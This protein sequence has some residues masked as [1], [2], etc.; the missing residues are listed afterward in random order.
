MNDAPLAK[1]AIRHDGVNMRVPPGRVAKGLDGQYS[2]DD[3]LK[4]TEDGAEKE[5]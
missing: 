5:P 4:K 3:A 1:Q 2:A